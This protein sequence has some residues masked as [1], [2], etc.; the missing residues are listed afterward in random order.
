MK[1]DCEV[2]DKEPS[3]LGATSRQIALGEKC[4]EKLVDNNVGWAPNESLSDLIEGAKARV[5]RPIPPSRKT[6]DEEEFGPC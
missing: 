5:P 6:P 3:I 4:Y 2:C 1:A